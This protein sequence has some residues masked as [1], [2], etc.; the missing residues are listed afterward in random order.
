MWV[1]PREIHTILSSLF[2]MRGF[3]FFIGGTDDELRSSTNRKEVA[4]EMGRRKN[5]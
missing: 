1:V 4:K 2:G 5:L 3:Y